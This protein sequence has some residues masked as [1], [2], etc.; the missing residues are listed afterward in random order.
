MLTKL[1]TLCIWFWLYQ[2]FPCWNFHHR[3]YFAAQ[4]CGQ[5]EL[6]WMVLLRC[7]DAF[8]TSIFYTEKQDMSAL[9]LNMDYI[10]IQADQTVQLVRAH[11]CTDSQALCKHCNFKYFK[12]VYS[13]IAV[14][15]VIISVMEFLMFWTDFCS[16][17]RREKG[18]EPLGLDHKTDYRNLK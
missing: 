6:P 9:V 14:S 1:F 7:C 4:V 13:R 5:S 10:Q 12:I 16:T 2:L 17:M 3:V 15:F 18:W 8:Q 11:V